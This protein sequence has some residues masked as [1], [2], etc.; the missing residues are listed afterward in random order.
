MLMHLLNCMLYV[1][2]GHYCVVERWNNMS[3]SGVN[4]NSFT[5]YTPKYIHACFIWIMIMHTCI[6]HTHTCTH[7]HT[8]THT[9]RHTRAHHTHTHTHTHMHTHT[10]HPKYV[11]LCSQAIDFADN[12]NFKF[13]TKEQQ[14]EFFSLKGMLNTY[15]GR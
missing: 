4:W 3:P 5:C 7:T 10:R 6:M 9:H 1:R 13:F 8:H 11:S 2:L 14:A 12:T 15:F